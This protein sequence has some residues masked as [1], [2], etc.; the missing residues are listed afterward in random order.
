M[1]T[2]HLID[3]DSKCVFIYFVAICVC[4]PQLNIL[5][6]ELPLSMAQPEFKH[7]GQTF[8]S[9]LLFHRLLVTGGQEE[10]ELLR[11]KQKLS[12][13]ILSH[14]CQYKEGFDTTEKVSIP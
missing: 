10:E 8:S 6:A 2:L 9:C 5:F 12:S 1:L 4:F 7:D 14:T 13:S 3:F 11:T